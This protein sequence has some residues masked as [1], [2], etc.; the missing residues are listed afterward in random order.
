MTVAQG[1]TKTAEEI[2]KAVDT[3]TEA[4]E[5]PHKVGFTLSAKDEKNIKAVHPKLQV[6][7]RFAAQISNVAFMVVEGA[8]SI[9]R[10]KEMVK[11]GLSKTMK[12]L[13]LL[14]EDGYSHAVDMYPVVDGR[15]VNDWCVPWLS[16]EQSME[17]W[18][19]MATAMKAAAATREVVLTWGGDWKSFKDGPHFQI[20]L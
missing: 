18:T 2:K 7:V 8:R 14:Q 3:K 16:K 17:A 10:Q 12:S 1:L 9:E 11:G 20:E 4:K 15:M 13:H 19:D 5:A 6:V